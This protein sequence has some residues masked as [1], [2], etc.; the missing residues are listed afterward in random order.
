MEYRSAGA[1]NSFADKLA[2]A[3]AGFRGTL[4]YVEWPIV[5]RL[6]LVLTVQ[7]VTGISAGARNKF[8]RP[9]PSLRVGP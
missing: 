3:R 8:E 6:A 9:R 7:M 1:D 2:L 5:Q 4:R